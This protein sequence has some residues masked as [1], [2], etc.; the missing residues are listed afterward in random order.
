MIGQDWTRLFVERLTFASFSFITSNRK[1][2]FQR[3]EA[4]FCGFERKATSRVSVGAGAEHE[5][6]THTIYEPKRYASICQDSRVLER[7][8]NW[9]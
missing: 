8:E 2:E 6:S 1:F 7:R 9:K 4:R 5:V 3:T